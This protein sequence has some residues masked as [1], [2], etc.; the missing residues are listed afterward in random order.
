MS[1]IDQDEELD[2]NLEP[3]LKQYAET[4]GENK[5][6]LESLLSLIK[7]S[8]ASSSVFTVRL[9]EQLRQNVSLLTPD[10]FEHNIINTLLYEI[11]WAT[12]YSREPHV[13][14]LFAEFLID[15]NSAYTSYVYK[16]LSMLVKSLFALVN[17]PT[18]PDL[19]D[20]ELL[21]S[22]AHSLID[23]LFRIAPACQ[24]QMVKIVEQSFPYMIKESC[25]QRA[26]VS[27]VL[28]LASN[29]AA[30]R[31]PLLEICVQKLLKI[32][33]N[34]NRESM[35]EAEKIDTDN[36]EEDSKSKKQIRKLRVVKIKNFNRY[37][38]AR[39]PSIFIY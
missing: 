38:H 10:L 32:D 37:I 7:K 18:T 16:S 3:I 29:H 39:Q 28:R 23:N 19:I 30:L 33:V 34:L 36:E 20:C 14:G 26:F 24:S 11:K 12:Y 4:R 8:Q 21:Y 25:V 5:F 13:L 31:L 35:I 9:L 27:N 1:K 22:M 2:F 15:L 6:E 17:E